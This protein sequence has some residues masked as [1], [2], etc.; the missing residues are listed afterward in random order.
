MKSGGLGDVSMALPGALHRLGVDVRV[1]VPGYSPLAAAFERAKTVA[2]LPHPGGVLA[3][4]R[5][6]TARAA[7]GV[8]LLILDCPEYYRR[9]GGA[10]QDARGR[11]WPDNHLR[12]GLLSRVAALLSTAATPAPWQPHVVHCNDWPTALAPAYAHYAGGAR[13][14]TVLTVHNLAFQGIFPP[15]TLAELGLPPQA[16]AIDG[17]E[18]YGKLSFL[19]G[20]LFFTDGLATVSPT[21]A[22]EIQTD[23]SGFGLGGL[24]RVRSARLIGIL[25]GIDTAAWNPATDAHLAARYDFARI[26]KKALNKAALQRSLGLAVEAEVPLLGVV[27]RLTEQK[28]LDVLAA[29]APM[30]VRLP[31]QLVMLGSGEK[32]FEQAVAALARQFPGGVAAVI[33]FDER[34][35]HLIEAGADIFVM[36]SRYEPCGLNQMYSLRYGTPP[37][38]RATGGLADTVIDC[39][40]AS[41]ADGSATGFV[42]HELAGAA[43][44]AAI[45]RAVSAWRDRSVWRALQKNGMAQDF[46]WERSARQY[47]ALYESLFAPR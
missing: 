7:S 31:A 18:Y 17:V 1:L 13:A 19:K 35:A 5:L 27:S 3:G 42:F 12:F 28:G 6:R 14:A 9:P 11:D 39:N 44:L 43:L 25:N 46:S 2:E 4:A 32:R 36:P 29:I 37:V 8:P 26:E 30:L 16:F 21:Y 40:P 45:G 10:Y 24:L 15:H 23:E 34:L 47:C 38:V 20:G 33:G 22:R 41:L